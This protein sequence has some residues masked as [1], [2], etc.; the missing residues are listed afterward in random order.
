MQKHATFSAWSERRQN[1]AGG[2]NLLEVLIVITIAGVLAAAA[3]PSFRGF[4]ASQRVKS[5]SFDLIAALTQ[6]RS[7]AIK[8]NANV[9]MTAVGGAWNNGW[10]IASGGTTLGTKSAYSGLTIADSGGVGAVTFR[11]DG[12][13]GSAAVKFT[14]NASPSLS[15]VT[16]R[17]VSLSLSGQPSSKTGSCS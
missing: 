13:L 9:S 10:T 7:E 17:C 1:R 4:I 2:F 16:A 12:R 3:A 11:G 15:G 6:T 8:R 5:A 14:V